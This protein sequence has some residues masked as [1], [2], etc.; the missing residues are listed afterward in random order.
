MKKNSKSGETQQNLLKLVIF[1]LFSINLD[2]FL[3][4]FIKFARFSS[5]SHF[6]HLSPSPVI[7]EPPI[8]RRPRFLEV[9][10]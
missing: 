7:P 9:L 3:L 6:E 4:S 1:G 5:F 2:I 10:K 8:T